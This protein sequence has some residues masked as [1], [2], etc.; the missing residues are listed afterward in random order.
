[1][2]HNKEVLLW[3]KVIALLMIILAAVNYYK[4]E[5]KQKV[6]VVESLLEE[7][8]KEYGSGCV[9]SAT[10]LMTDCNIKS[11]VVEW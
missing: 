9:L 4:T 1:M 3:C 7:C 6:K 5:H 8:R 11:K 2:E 10:P